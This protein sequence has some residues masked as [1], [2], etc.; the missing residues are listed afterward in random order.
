M[1]DTTQTQPTVQVQS[2]PQAAPTAGVATPDGSLGT[3][4]QPSTT[5][6]PGQTGQVE[7]VLGLEDFSYSEAD[8]LKL[9]ESMQSATPV[10]PT[11]VVPPVQP[12]AP[13][14]T[15]AALAPTVPTAEAVA[16]EATRNKQRV[17]VGNSEVSTLAQQI[18]HSRRGSDA[19]VDYTTAA[20]L[21]HQALG[22][23]APAAPVEVIPPAREVVPT[24]TSDGEAEMRVL[25]RR[26]A[27]AGDPMSLNYDPVA[28][29]DLK[30]E[31][32]RLTIRLTRESILQEQQERLQQD[33]TSK[34]VT[35]FESTVA[36][37]QVAHPELG[38]ATSPLS[39]LAQGMY[40][41]ARADVNHAD[42]AKTLT[43]DGI[44]HFIG[45][46]LAV[47]KPGSQTLSSPSAPSVPTRP[48]LSAVLGSG[49]S[50]PAADP[51]A[52]LAERFSN[53]SDSDWSRLEYSQTG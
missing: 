24:T 21:A 3:P 2:A 37:A 49:L 10:A 4:Q 33:A 20:I 29:A 36:A 47:V 6:P 38:N 28:L 32:C 40:N 52:S 50:A 23:T 19:S 31:E 9:I 12:A 16:A 53:F 51:G 5:A 43:G 22:Q 15:P 8:A 17:E 1:T 46:A 25:A 11:V 18:Y 39:L 7:G 13:A 27:E 35:T 30:V 26:I 41:A 45:Q 48:S 14:P 34:Y 44:A 42:H